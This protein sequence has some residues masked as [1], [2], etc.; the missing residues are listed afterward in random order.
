MIALE[1]RSHPVYRE[2]WAVIGPAIHGAGTN[3]WYGPDTLRACLMA[4]ARLEL[5]A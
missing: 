2:Q 3:I 5:V 1:V 4:R